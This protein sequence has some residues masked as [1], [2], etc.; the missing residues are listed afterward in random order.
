MLKAMTHQ[1]NP[2]KQTGEM[3]KTKHGERGKGIEQRTK[4]SGC[5]TR[6][7]KGS[8][9]SRGGL[10]EG[11]MNQEEERRGPRGWQTKGSVKKNKGPELGRKGLTSEGV[12]ERGDGLSGK[13]KGGRKN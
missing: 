2:L 13:Y 5:E 11:L 1:M 3:F 7:Q 12:E 4:K 6:R 10:K 8:F 9:M